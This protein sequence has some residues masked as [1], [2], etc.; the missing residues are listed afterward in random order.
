[1]SVDLVLRAV[2][3]LTCMYT[4]GLFVTVMSL[5][6][7]NAAG[8]AAGPPCGDGG[9]HMVAYQARFEQVATPADSRFVRGAVILLADNI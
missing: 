2:G 9:C 5:A 6:A 1:M 7:V 4:V 3:T 8:Y